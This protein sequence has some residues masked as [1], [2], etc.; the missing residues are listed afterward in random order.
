SASGSPDHHREANGSPRLCLDPR[1]AT[2]LDALL[3]PRRPRAGDFQ[4][5]AI[6]TDIHRHVER[7][8]L[9]AGAEA[10]GA[11]DTDWVL[12]PALRNAGWNEGDL[13]A[14]GIG[15]QHT[16]ALQ[17]TLGEVEVPLLV[18]GHAVE[19]VLLAEVDQRAPRAA[20]QAIVA[21]REGVELH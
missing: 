13:T 10:A 17:A 18:H 12:R 7:R 20:D 5:D 8:F 6:K 19:A 14:V 16:G 1:R 15:D 3:F 21:E 9:L 4:L 2:L 11:R